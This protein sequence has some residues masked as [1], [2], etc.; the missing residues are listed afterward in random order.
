MSPLRQQMQNDMV[1]RGMAARTQESY[2][3]A[4]RGL[5]KY[6]RRPPDAV[7]VEEVQSYVLHLLQERGLSVSTCSLLANGL[8]FFGSSTVPRWDKARRNST[9]PIPS[10]PRGCP[11]S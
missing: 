1:I 9:S 5:A 6:Y 8:R 4:V 2:L 10:N 7:S 3:S 11:R